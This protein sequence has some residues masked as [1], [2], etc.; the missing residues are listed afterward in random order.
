MSMEEKLRFL[1]DFQAN[2]S[3]ARLGAQAADNPALQAGAGVRGLGARGWG[4][5]DWT[6]SPVPFPIAQLSFSDTSRSFH[7]MPEPAEAVVTPVNNPNIAS[8]TQVF[9]SMASFINYRNKEFA[10]NIPPQGSN[11]IYGSENT[12]VFQSYYQRSSDKSL[13]ATSASM[14]RRRLCWRTARDGVYGMCI[15]NATTVR[16]RWRQ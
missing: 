3:E 7:H 5:N 15:G 6:G 9:P 14:T 12:E 4:V 2:Q 11:G 13:S 16:M 8:D 10:G 1:L